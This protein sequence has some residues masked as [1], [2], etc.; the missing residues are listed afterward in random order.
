MV[1]LTVFGLLMASVYERQSVNYESANGN[2]NPS[3]YRY[4]IGYLLASSRFMRPYNL[5]AFAVPE[6]G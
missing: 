6:R 1:Q 3:G 2:P 5:V 4:L